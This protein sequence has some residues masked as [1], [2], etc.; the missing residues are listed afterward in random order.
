M[1]LHR[2]HCRRQGCWD[3]SE[4]NIQQRVLESA[5][6]NATAGKAA[7]FRPLAGAVF[8][9]PHDHSWRLPAILADGCKDR[10]GDGPTIGVH[11]RLGWPLI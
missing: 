9:L 3:Q 5:L 2:D 1:H 8:F 4:L 11:C 6:S 10:T 7:W